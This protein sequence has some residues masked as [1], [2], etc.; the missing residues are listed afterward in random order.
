M[1]LSISIPSIT[2]ITL[3]FALLGG[4]LSKCK[5]VMREKSLAGQEMHV[6]L[7]SVMLLF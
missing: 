5:P 1:A 6:Q 2:L 7:E 4:S 3:Y